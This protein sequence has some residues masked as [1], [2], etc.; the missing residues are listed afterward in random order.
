M[1]ADRLLAALI[2]GLLATSLGSSLA[3]F[4]LYKLGLE[5]FTQ[6]SDLDDDIGVLGMNLFRG[7]DPTFDVDSIVAQLLE[8]N[9]TGER[10]S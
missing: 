2:I 6:V 10:S 7:D 1:S 5:Q 8:T 4:H 9:S 3:A